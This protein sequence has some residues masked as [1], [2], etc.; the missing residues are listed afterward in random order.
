MG[1]FT[2][3]PTID[4]GRLNEPAT[5]ADELPKLADALFRVGF[6]YLVNTGVERLLE[7]LHGRLPKAF[8]IPKAE[9]ERVNMRNSP[10]FLGY[11][12][13]GAE[14][15]AARTDLR[16]QYDFG[17]FGSRPG[18][19]LGT[20][21]PAP[22]KD[23]PAWRSLEGPSQYPALPGFQGAVET[24]MA[25]LDGVSRLFL[26]FVAES[27]FLPADAFD[28]FLGNMHRLKLVKYPPTPIGQPGQGVGPH[29]DSTGLFTFLSQDD[30]GGLEVL[31]KGDEWIAAP[32]IA[33][34]LVVN[35]QQG[36]EAITGGVWPAT[37]HRVVS[38]QG[39][40]VRYSEPFFQG[41]RLD[42]T[43]DEL[44]SSAAHIVARIPVTDDRKKRA[45]DVPSEFLSPLFSC[46]GEAQ[47]RNRVISHP[48]VGQ[49]WYPELYD[50]FV[51]QGL[52]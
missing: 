22:T 38:P 18:A 43:T 45:V 48:D 47:L 11:T 39:T 35:V 3:V 8:S 17:L 29:K 36:F 25:A 52:Q 13:L 31:S 14:T 32:P 23:D 37:T 4:F 28:D 20:M 34:S 21:P 26:G 40:T 7:D 9:R 46:F 12:A 49:R 24:Y 30:V 15:T 41:V 51:K 42:L 50:K 19:A 2:S 27:L 44:R 33:G 6:L 16:E 5:R 1:D 10:S